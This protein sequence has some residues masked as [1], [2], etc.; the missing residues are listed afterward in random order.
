MGAGPITTPRA[1][2]VGAL[3][4][5]IKEL[6]ESRLFNVWVEGE[7]SAC[8]QH[9]TGAVY[10]TLKDAE[11][12]LD[13][14]IWRTAAQR[15]RYRP[16][17][18]EKV[19]VYGRI[20]VFPP[21]GSYQLIIERLEPAGQGELQAQLQA[22]KAKLAAEGLFDH[23]RKKALIRLPR[24][25]GVVTSPTSAARRDIEAVI[26]RRSPQIPIWIYPAKVQGEGAAADIERGIRYL[27]RGR[28][29]DV[30]IVGRGGGSVEALWAFNAEG[31]ARAI[32]DSPI[33]VI[34][35]VG[36]ETDVTIADL[37]ADLRAPTPSAAA[38]SAVPVRDDLRQLL[39]RLDGRAARA[40]ARVIE[41]REARL[42]SAK[43][44]LTTA[45]E[46]HDRRLQ[47]QQLGRRLSESIARAITDRRERLRRLDL[48]VGAQHPTERLA[49]NR[50]RLGA[51][52]TRLH[53]CGG[54]AVVQ[55]RAHQ[56]HLE[57]RLHGVGGDAV[58]RARSD[59]RAACA[60][61]NA[62]SPLASLGRGYSITRVG[63][64]VVR[65][66]EALAKGDSLE[67]ILYEGRVEATVMATHPLESIDE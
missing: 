25:V 63:G 13:C 8:K 21:R 1:L 22:L 16:A 5:R 32:A 27:S 11:A 51:L 36:H 66:A 10:L 61:L 55:G 9:Q 29:I 3:T 59:L 28:T 64:K 12:R 44:R 33:P 6:L 34:S 19:R 43:H 53:T 62:L 14:V 2:S 46:L 49:Y 23:R 38:E 50:A 40:V 60:Q 24:A 56:R 7:L 35:A 17:V 65:S 37:V 58:T 4:H 26:F 45:L 47:L 41:R 67:I 42:Q 48:R 18:G 54:T 15:I 31:V 39:E 30:I 57:Q 52:Q 20:N